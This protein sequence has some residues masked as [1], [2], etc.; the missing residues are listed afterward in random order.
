MRKYLKRAEVDQLVANATS[1]GRYG[2]RDG[3]M[4]R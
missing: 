4:L 1:S 2:P 3:L